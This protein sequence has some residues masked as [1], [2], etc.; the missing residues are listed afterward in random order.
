MLATQAVCEAW[1]GIAE[2]T[3][4]VHVSGCVTFLL[5]NGDAHKNSFDKNADLGKTFGLGDVMFR[6]HSP[7]LLELFLQNTLCSTITSFSD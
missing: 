2:N 7:L 3:V 1:Y 4:R 5:W 6:A